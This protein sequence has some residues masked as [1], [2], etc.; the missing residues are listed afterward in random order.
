MAKPYSISLR[1]ITN[2]AIALTLIS[3]L[4]RHRGSVDWGITRRKL[5]AT[6]G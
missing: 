6:A 4:G 2:P 5:V 1:E 3:D